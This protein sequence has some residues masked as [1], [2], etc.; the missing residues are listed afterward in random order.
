MKMG[1]SPRRDDTLPN[2]TFIGAKNVGILSKFRI[3]AIDLYLRGDSLAIF[4]RNSQRL[5]ASIGRF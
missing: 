1:F 2:F 5:Y 4:L 3:L